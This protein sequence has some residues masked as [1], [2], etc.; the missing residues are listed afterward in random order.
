[1][2]HIELFASLLTVIALWFVSEKAYALGFALQALSCGIWVFWCYKLKF[3][4]LLTL[5]AAMGILY[6]KSLL[7]VI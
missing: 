3:P 4:Y 5:E 2:R 7:G 6:L 1:M